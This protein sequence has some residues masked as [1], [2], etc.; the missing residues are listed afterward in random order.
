MGAGDR[1]LG[2]MPDHTI[3]RCEA[4]ST[5]GFFGMEWPQG[6]ATA[7][8]AQCLS[9]QALP[10]MNSRPDWECEAELDSSGRRLGGSYRLAVYR[11]TSTSTVSNGDATTRDPTVS[12]TFHP[13]VSPTL[14]PTLS[15]TA[16]PTRNPIHDPSENSGG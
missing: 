3:E 6:S 15:P 16:T 5:G 11:L 1:V 9:L 8:E 2:H 4:R 12:P 14:A 13:T 10:V 7:G